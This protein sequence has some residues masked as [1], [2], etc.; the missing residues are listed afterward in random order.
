MG[1]KDWAHWPDLIEVCLSG[2]SLLLSRAGKNALTAT[3]HSE[4]QTP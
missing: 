1:A 4:E 2:H 3:Q